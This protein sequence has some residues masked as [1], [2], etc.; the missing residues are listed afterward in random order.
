MKLKS[1]LLQQLFD[2]AGHLAFIDFGFSLQRNR[3]GDDLPGWDKYYDFIILTSVF[4][5]FNIYSLL[6][7]K[8]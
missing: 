1:G 7:I 6:I 4:D 5:S 2:L 3:V 8:E